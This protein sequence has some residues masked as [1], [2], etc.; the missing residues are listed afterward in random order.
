MK[1]RYY[2]NIPLF[3][4]F[5]GLLFAFGACKQEPG[6]GEESEPGP[7]QESGGIPTGGTASDPYFWGT[8]IRM[9]NGEEYQ[10]AETYIEYGGKYYTNASGDS[11]ALTVSGLGRFERQS[12]SILVTELTYPGAATSS[13]IPLFRKGGT[14]LDYTV[15]LVGFTNTAARAGSGISQ[16]LGGL[17]VQGTSDT[18]RSSTSEALSADDG[19]VHLTAKVA[20]D[21]QT[22]SVSSNGATPEDGQAIVLDGSNITVTGI[23]V[24][25][26]GDYMGTIPIVGKNDCSLKI[27]GKI[28]DSAKQGG[29]LYAGKTYPM[30]LTIQNISAVT[31]DTAVVTVTSGADCLTLSSKA[32]LDGYVFST[33]PSGASKT[34]ELDVQCGSFSEPYIDTELKIEINI[35]DSGSR[36]WIDSV[37]LRIFRGQMPVTIA[38]QSTENNARAKLNGFLMYPDGNSKF[39]SIA[40][41]GEGRVYVPTFKASQSYMLAFCGASS[42]GTLSDSTEMFYTVAVDSKQKKDVV[43]SGEEALSYINFGED[44]GRNETEDTAYRIGSSNTEFEAY[45][46]AGERDFYRISVESDS[47]EYYGAESYYSLSADAVAHNAVT[48][49]WDLT[50]G[51]HERDIRLYRNGELYASGCSSPYTVSGLYGSTEYTFQLRGA[52]NDEISPLITVTTGETPSL[53]LSCTSVT[54]TSATLQFVNNNGTTGTAYIFKDGAYHSSRAFTADTA[55]YTVTV[56]GLSSSTSYTFVIKDGTGSAASEISNTVTAKTTAVPPVVGSPT[57]TSVSADGK[58]DYAGRAVWDYISFTWTGCSSGAAQYRVYRWGDSTATAALST[59]MR[60]TA[61]TTTAGTTYKDTDIGGLSLEYTENY[62]IVPLDYEGTEQKDNST[63][64]RVFYD[65]SKGGFYYSTE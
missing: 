10:F 3:M 2:R 44:G 47:T 64:L 1:R 11:S 57:I 39:F 37:P 61:V 52:S 12:D 26:T 59:I 43:V 33:M 58:Y 49:S 62:A 6:G 32:N 50:A 14:N 60:G 24:N 56:G 46:K 48:L 20:G 31:C 23:Q 27:T 63:I 38:A 15:K 29:Y 22:I 42:S 55:S 8:W 5:A 40:D 9:D 7:G 18:Y 36:T 4:F 21:V 45:L 34:I 17:L 41:G 54:N 19:T 51:I 53:Y 65:S 16:G 35:S 30:T 13:T 28:P 25:N